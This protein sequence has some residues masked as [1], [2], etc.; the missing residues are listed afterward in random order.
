[1]AEVTTA[2]PMAAAVMKY[3]EDGSVDWGNMWDSF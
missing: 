3:R 2:A 1:M